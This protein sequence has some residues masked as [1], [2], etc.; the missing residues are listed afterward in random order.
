M[1][2]L[3]SCPYDGDYRCPSDGACIRAYEV[4]DGSCTCG[5]CSD[6]V[7]CSEFVIE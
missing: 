3:Q 1:T 6:E 4:C 7:N 2:G 5:D